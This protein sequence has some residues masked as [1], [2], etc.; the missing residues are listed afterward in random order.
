[1]RTVRLRRQVRTSWLARL[2]RGLRPDRNPLRRGI[3]R[4]ETAILAE[5]KISAVPVLTMGR[6]VAGVV[7]EADLVA[8][9]DQAARRARFGV[10]DVVDKLTAPAA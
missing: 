9:E 1:M 8:A 10:D 5:H 4:A 2:I 7:S 6:H 3:D